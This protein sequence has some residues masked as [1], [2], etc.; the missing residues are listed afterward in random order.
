[1]HVVEPEDCPSPIRYAYVMTQTKMFGGMFGY[2]GLYKLLDEMAKAWRNPVPL[3]QLVADAN[4]V[5]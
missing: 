2:D 3:R 5:I 4:L 1:M